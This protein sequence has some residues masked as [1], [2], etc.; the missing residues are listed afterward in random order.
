LFRSTV[1]FRQVDFGEA[2]FSRQANFINAEFNAN[3]IF[4]QGRFES[5]VPDF[6]GAK[7]HEAT[8]WHGVHW[9]SAPREENSAQAQVLLT[10][11]SSRKWSG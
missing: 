10:N 3:T 4:A 5:G 9:P 2:T 1:F 11:V 7:M 8:E 6:R